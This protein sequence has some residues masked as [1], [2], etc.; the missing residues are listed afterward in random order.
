MGRYTSVQAYADNN[1]NVRSIPYDQAIGGG[2]AGSGGDNN[3]DGNNQQANNSKAGVVTE[4]VSNPYG[5]TAGA[6]SGEFHVYRHARAREAARWKELDASEQHALDEQR[7]GEELRNA[8]EEEAQKTARRRKK[9]QREKEAKQRKKHL[10]AAGILTS[11]GEAA[12]DSSSKDEVN[13]QEAGDGE[14]TYVPEKNRPVDEANETAG[15]DQAKQ[16]TNDSGK[17][18]GTS[19]AD[20]PVLEEIPNDGS[21]LEIMKRKLQAEQ[22]TRKGQGV[23]DDE[24]GPMMPPPAKKIIVES[25]IIDEDDD[26][27]EGPMPLR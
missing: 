13:D 2:G 11:S 17:D 15:Q 4:K 21:F 20:V 7:F 23:E 9:R 26:D 6:G 22:G 3:K 16:A 25:R 10:K 8:H 19:S 27:E 5:S 1:A 12:N 14:F 18:S 24:E